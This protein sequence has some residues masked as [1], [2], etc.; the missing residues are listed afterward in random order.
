MSDNS[1]LPI[2]LIV[3]LGHIRKDPSAMSSVARSIA[4][5]FPNI[6]AWTKRC[7][8]R[9]CLIF[10]NV[11]V[12]CNYISLYCSWSWFHHDFIVCKWTIWICLRLQKLTI[13]T[14]KQEPEAWSNMTLLLNHCFFSRPA[15]LIFNISIVCSFCILGYS[16]QINTCV[17][18]FIGWLK[19]NYS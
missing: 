7:L 6:T 15:N 14:L 1:V 9:N 19:F 18:A 2:E 5:G 12:V 8:P 4:T 13:R 17:C 10:F 11:K 3:S 16:L